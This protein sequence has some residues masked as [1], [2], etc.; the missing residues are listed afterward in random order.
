MISG[1]HFY[2]KLWDYNS[3]QEKHLKLENWIEGSEIYF[4]NSISITGSVS[5]SSIR[6]D[7]KEVVHKFDLMGRPTENLKQDQ[8]GFILYN[9]GSVTKKIKK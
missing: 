5:I 4:P 8:I 9:D 3:N 6:M 1:E 2:L 7:E